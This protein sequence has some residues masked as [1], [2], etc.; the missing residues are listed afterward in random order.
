MA[1]PSYK[2][3][4]ELLKKGATVEA[5]EQI[6]ALREGAIALQEEN[7]GLREKVKSLEEALRTKGQ[8]TFDGASYWLMEGNSKEGPFCQ[9][10]YDMSGKLVRLQDWGD[11]WMCFACKN[12][13]DKK[14]R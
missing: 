6:M 1:L 12:L 5:Q 13:P 3:I 8:L 4:V 7:F 10:C 14:A 9:H 11:S 2:D